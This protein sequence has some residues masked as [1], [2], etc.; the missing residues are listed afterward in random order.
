MSAPSR[1]SLV[2]GAAWSAPAVVLASSVPALAASVTCDPT[3]LQAA[4][5]KAF[6]DARQRLVNQAGP[7]TINFYQVVQSGN[8]FLGTAYTNLR[9]DGATPI[10]MVDMQGN[11]VRFRIDFVHTS[12]PLDTRRSKNLITSWGSTARQPDWYS[13]P[14]VGTPGTE[15]H[16]WTP[17]GT[18]TPTGGSGEA[19][20]AMNFGDGA[21]FGGRIVEKVVVTPLAQP[22]SIIRYTSTNAPGI[23]AVVP[24]AGCAATDVQ[25]V[26]DAALAA[27]VRRGQERV[28]V[29]LAVAGPAV[30]G[31]VP[32]NSEN[33]QQVA[34]VA[35]DQAVDS[36]VVKDGRTAGAGD[37][38]F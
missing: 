19:D 12:G 23:G 1:R 36:F 15:T 28:A 26:Y 35:V 4:V 16:L 38:L 20:L 8:G 37:G 3:A 29:P 11:P 10:E 13:T 22:T 2:K 9:N 6:A 25:P 32:P 14:R 5:D 24:P 31:T 33:N 27:W 7:L 18:I 17:T 21:T 30:T 34:P